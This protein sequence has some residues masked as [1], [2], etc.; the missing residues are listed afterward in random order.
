M[1]EP[2]PR[3]S[4]SPLGGQDLGGQSASLVADPDASDTDSALG[5]SVAGS[6]YSTSLAS[7]VLNYQYENGRRY[8][9]YRQGSYVLPNDEQEQ[10]RLD[11]LHHIF[12]MITGGPILRAPLG[13]AR[14]RRVLDMGCGTGI[15][16]IDCADEFPDAIVIGT[17]LSPIQPSWVPPNCKFYVDDIEAEWTYPPVEH[18]DYIHGRA[19]LGSI[20]YWKE[21][22]SKTFNNLKP[23][24][25]LEIQDFPS[26]IRSDDDTQ[27]Y[28]PYLT[29]WLEKLNDGLARIGKPSRIVH[30]LKG[31][32]EEVGF[33]DVHEEM[34][35]VPLGPWAKGRKNKELGLFFL[36]HALDSVEAFTLALFTRELGYSI[37][38][39]QVTI[40]RTKNDLRNPRAHLYVPFYIV[41]GR[42]PG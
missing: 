5:E 15:W 3:V 4:D 39:V 42:K 2:V 8:H 31:Y 40:A 12:R 22:F 19:L 38:E 16:A 26:D 13:D 32:M 9:A 18:F 30:L 23:G 37:D 14:P 36:A 34:Y 1:S 11:M 28:V 21:L 25:I 35:K 6:S 24:G 20:T 27:S 33:V 10:D 41:W 17:D 7:S 29:D